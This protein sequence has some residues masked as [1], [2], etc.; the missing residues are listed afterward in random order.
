VSFDLHESEGQAFPLAGG[1][2]PIVLLPE[3]MEHPVNARRRRCVV[4]PYADITDLTTTNQAA[5]IA[6]KQ[7]VYIL[8]RNL[9]A[10]T[11]GPEN[12]VRALARRIA[13]QPGAEAQLARMLEI[14][15]LSASAGPLRAT[16]ALAGVCV[17]VFCAQLWIGQTVQIVGEFSSHFFRAGDTWRVITANLIHAGP[18]VPIHLGLNMLALVVLGALV[19]RPLGAVRTITI[20]GVSGIAAMLTTAF[21]DSVPV[22]GASG[23]V[24]GLVGAAIWLEY[25]WPDRL[26]AWWRYPRRSLLLVLA[27]NGLLGFMVPFISGTAHFGGFVGGFAATALIAGGG[28]GVGAPSTAVWASSALVVVLT[29]AAVGAAGLQIVRPDEYALRHAT[30]MAELPEVSTDELN[31][32]AW[33]IAI[34]PE[35]SREMVEA[36]LPLA[37]RAAAQSKREDPNILDTLAE[38]QFQ[39]GKLEDALRTID[40]AIAQ[41]PGEDYFREQR[42]RFTG[43]RDI[44]DRPASPLPSWFPQQP[45]EEQP[46]YTDPG[47]SI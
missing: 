14:E 1:R 10:Q 12:L 21:A 8:P 35:P 30:Q 11:G 25:T 44:D 26:P 36:A 40:E 45:P 37:E 3:G 27:L 41:A 5:W 29:V 32:A 47:L 2:P 13:E 42:R 31:N 38:V 33:M 46:L 22:V 9:F 34:S 24:F 43:E 15:R 19:E 17:A 7:S 23:V 4:T 28:R 16:F 20:M 6:S 39:L 18:E